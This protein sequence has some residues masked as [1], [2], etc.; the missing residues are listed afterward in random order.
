MASFIRFG[1]NI[2]FTC[3]MAAFGGGNP[4][5]SGGNPFGGGGLKGGLG[6]LKKK[7]TP[8]AFVE[9]DFSIAKEE[10]WKKT[11][12]A[13]MREIDSFRLHV[14]EAKE[15]SRFSI[16]ESMDRVNLQDQKHLMVLCGGYAGVRFSS[17][18]RCD[19]ALC[20]LED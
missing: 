3:T 2:I 6:M 4:F 9:L 12:T 18:V 14:P 15:R 5:A 16:P 19:C 20:R 13:R 17:E 7:A 11:A 1:H 8:K 10:Q